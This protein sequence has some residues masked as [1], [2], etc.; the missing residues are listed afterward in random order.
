VTL[1]ERVARVRDVAPLSDC[2]ATDLKELDEE[3]DAA[4]RLEDLPGRWQA[5]IL[6]AEASLDTR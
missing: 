4:E 5:A 2:S 6:E 1:L 3:I